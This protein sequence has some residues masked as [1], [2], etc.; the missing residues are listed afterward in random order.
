MSLELAAKLLLHV[1]EL[2]TQFPVLVNFGLNFL[3]SRLN[4]LTG[5]RNSLF[6]DCHPVLSLLQLLTEMRVI[7]LIYFLLGANLLF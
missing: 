4:Q 6:Q 5:I 2:D 3:V 7:L 1:P